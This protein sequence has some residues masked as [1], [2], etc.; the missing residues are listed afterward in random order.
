MDI[1]TIT[2]QNN[3]DMFYM[4]DF[5]FF[6]FFSFFFSFFFY[7]GGV[8]NFSFTEDILGRFR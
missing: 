5:A 6:F 3:F 1:F 4:P 2:F 7:G 8:Y